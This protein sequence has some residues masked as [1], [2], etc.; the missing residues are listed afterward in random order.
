MLNC[1]F[2]LNF[3]QQWSDIGSICSGPNLLLPESMQLK[4]NY[5]VTI[6]ICI[7]I[8]IT[9]TDIDAFY[10]EHKLYLYTIVLD[11]SINMLVLV[12]VNQTWRVEVNP[13]NNKTS[14]LYYKQKRSTK[15]VSILFTM[16][17]SYQPYYSSNYHGYSIHIHSDEMK[18]ERRL[19]WPQC[20][21]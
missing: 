9:N 15:N 3:W 7:Y 17:M 21:Y 5:F 18:C 11:D 6:Y 12:P 19:D 13:T 10:N 8:Y 1:Q 2:H 14:T 20:L 4:P 16:Y